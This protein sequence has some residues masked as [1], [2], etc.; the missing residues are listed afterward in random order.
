[1]WHDKLP[2]PFLIA[3]PNPPRIAGNEHLGESNDLGT[4][5]RR[6]LNEF[7]RFGNRRIGVEP[8][9]LCLDDRG[10]NNRSVGGHGSSLEGLEAGRSQPCGWLLRRQFP[11]VQSRGARPISLARDSAELCTSGL[12]KSLVPLSQSEIAFHFLPSHWIRR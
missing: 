11:V 1:M 9:R 2:C 5:S 6:P 12:E 8:H 7:D 10:L 4:F 3:E